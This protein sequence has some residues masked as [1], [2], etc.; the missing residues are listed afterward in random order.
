ML[1]NALFVPGARTDVEALH[2]N[3][4][5]LAHR[6]GW[7]YLLL[8]WGLWNQGNGPFT[9]YAFAYDAD[10]HATTLGTKTI[11]VSN[12]TANKPF[13][14]LDTDYGRRGRGRSGTT[15]GR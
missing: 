8:T 11:T 15:G 6:A 10:G 4:W 2:P 5:P 14:A 1:A 12:A 9:L 13:G 7:G 3:W